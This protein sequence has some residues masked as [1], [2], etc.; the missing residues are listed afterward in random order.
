MRVWW[1]NIPGFV[2]ALLVVLAAVL[3]IRGA[4]VVAPPLVPTPTTTVTPGP[5]PAP[6][7]FGGRPSNPV[8]V[9]RVPTSTPRP[10]TTATPAPSPAASPSSCAPVAAEAPAD[11]LEA[12]EPRDSRFVRPGSRFAANGR[13]PPDGVPC[14]TRLVTPTEVPA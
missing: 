10:T 8:G 5:Q 12:R 14:P 9:L 2:A 11:R 7:R 13:F 3:V 4:A 1:R 6:T